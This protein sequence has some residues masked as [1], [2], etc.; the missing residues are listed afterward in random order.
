MRKYP[1]GY[2]QYMSYDD[3]QPAD[4]IGEKHLVFIQEH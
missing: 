4:Q 1:V 2:T 3:E